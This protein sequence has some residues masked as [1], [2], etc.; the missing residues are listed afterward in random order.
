MVESL[1]EVAD[2]KQQWLMVE[3]HSYLPAHVKKGEKV[4]YVSWIEETYE[5]PEEMLSKEKTESSVEETLMLVLNSLVSEPD[6]LSLTEME[7]REKLATNFNYT[8][9]N[10]SE[11]EKEIATN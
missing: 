11:S 10:L 4:A 9:P 8:N 2:N 7:H 1:V 5:V 6:P 3:N